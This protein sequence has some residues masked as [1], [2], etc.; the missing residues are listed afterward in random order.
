MMHILSFI[1]KLIKDNL[2]PILSP[3]RLNT[4]PL[5]KLFLIKSIVF[6]L[7]YT[8]S[9]L[10]DKVSMGT[11]QDLIIFVFA[12]FYNFYTIYNKNV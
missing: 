2:M 3:A 7:A 4:I 10:G 6:N 1:I 12:T 5:T 11:L 8:Y 9:R